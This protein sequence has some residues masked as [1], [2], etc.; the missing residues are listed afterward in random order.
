MADTPRRIQMSRQHPWRAEHP[1]AIIVARPTKYGNP[2]RYRQRVGGLVHHH[3]DY[4]EAW[5]YEGRISGPDMRHDSF[6]PGDAWEPL[7]VRWATR[8]EIVELFRRT[9]IEPDRGMHWAYPSGNGNLA[10]F[11]VEDARRELA[12]RDLACWCP[13]DQP[14]HADVL[15]SLANGAQEETP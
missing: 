10:R 7:W 9:L 6:G 12:G 15:L 1:N 13:L 5:E 2:F 8:E 11:T 4:P 14:C 3:P